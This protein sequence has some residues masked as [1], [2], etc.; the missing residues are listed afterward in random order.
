MRTL[1]ISI[2]DTEFKKFGLKEDQLTFS[3][4]I[5]LLSKELA[6]QNL[7]KCIEL[8]SKYGISGMSMDE[9]SEEVKQVR[10]N[11]KDRH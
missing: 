1:N 7:N 5:E 6:I 10:R 8:S 11:A 3:E 2:S 4:L 9:I